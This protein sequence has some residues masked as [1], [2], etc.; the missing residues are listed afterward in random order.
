MVPLGVGIPGMRERLRRLGG[1]LEVDFGRNGTTVV[2]TLPITA[3]PSTP[4]ES[5]EMGNLPIEQPQADP[6]TDCHPRSRI[7]IADDHEL[8]RRGLRGL[9]ESHNEW[10]VCGEAVE[11]NEAVQKTRELRPDLVIMD[12]NMP[13]LTGLD[14]AERIR[15]EHPATKILFFSVY[16]SPHVVREILNVGGNGFVAKSRAGSD[17]VNAVRIVLGGKTFFPSVSK[18][19][20][21]A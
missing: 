4:M 9:I 18:T 19:A 14:A 16:H 20:H 2:A 7:L 11:G 3:R 5:V 15:K 6:E 21:L 12:V 8:M 17:L 10:A 1:Q 13:N